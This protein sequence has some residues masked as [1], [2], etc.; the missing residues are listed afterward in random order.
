[1][2]AAGGGRSV[3]TGRLPNSHTGAEGQQRIPAVF[4]GKPLFSWVANVRLPTASVDAA[5]IGR[6]NEKK[7]AIKPIQM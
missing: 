4:A 3:A 7:P 5:S 6:V 2:A 1:M